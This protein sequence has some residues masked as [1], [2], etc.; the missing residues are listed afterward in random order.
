[1]VGIAVVVCFAQGIDW[2]GLGLA[3]VISFGGGNA[4]LGE[5]G[6]GSDGDW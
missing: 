6:R 2:E 3:Q 4:G 1:M 5:V